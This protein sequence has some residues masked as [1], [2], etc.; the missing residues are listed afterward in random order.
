MGGFFGERY[1]D[2]SGQHV[3]ALEI[4][5]GNTLQFYANNMGGRG[6]NNFTIVKGEGGYGPEYY[7]IKTTA[8]LSSYFVIL[9]AKYDTL[10]IAEDYV[11][12]G[13]TYT[14]IRYRGK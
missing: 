13:Y 10:K 1:V 14:F 7:D 5:K 6:L 2:T 3:L 12:D 4:N 11:D 9:K 8:T